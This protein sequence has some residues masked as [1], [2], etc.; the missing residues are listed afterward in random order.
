MN[1]AQIVG[2]EHTSPAFLE[3]LEHVRYLSMFLVR[4]RHKLSPSSGSLQAND[5]VP[6]QAYYAV[7]TQAYCAVRIR[8]YHALHE[9][10]HKNTIAYKVLCAVKG[11]GPQRGHTLGYTRGYTRPGTG[12]LHPVAI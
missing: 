2:A 8:A 1:A 11:A 10:N 6:L 9:I 4:S 7:C 5:A 3:L 12:S